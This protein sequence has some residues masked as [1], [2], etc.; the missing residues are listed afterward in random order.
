MVVPAGSTRADEDP[1]G[2]VPRPSAASTLPAWPLAALF[3][4]YPVW[5]AVGLVDVAS[6][7]V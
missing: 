6:R 2:V 5:W 1:P 3:A 7:A 4:G